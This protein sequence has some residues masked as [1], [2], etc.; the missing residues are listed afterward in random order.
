M[1]Q[2]QP[3]VSHI[4]LL[5]DGTEVS[6][7]VLGRV[8]EITVDQHV[9]LPHMFSLRF[10][11][12]GMKL[13]DEGPFDLATPVTIRAKDVA[14]KQFT[15]IEGEVTALE[16]EFG[17]GMIAELVVHGYDVSHRLY[18]M[19]RSTTYL[20][21]KDSDIAR[22]IAN[23]AGLKADVE[24]TATVYEHIYQHNQSDLRFLQQRARRIGYVCFVADKTL[25]FKK[26]TQTPASVE[27]AWGDD[28]LA[29]SPRMT[30]TEQAPETLIQGWD[31]RKKERILGRA[32]KGELYPKTGETKTGDQWAS[33]FGKNRIT[34]VH[35][36]VV[37]QAEAD[38]VATARQNELS[39]A[40]VEA[41]GE[42]IRRPDVQAGK[43]VTINGLG[44]RF[45]GD[46]LVTRVTHRYTDAGFRSRFHVTGARN[47]LLAEQLNDANS[48]PLWGGVVPAIVTN[49]DDSNGWGRV[50]VKFPWMSDDEESTWA[51]VLAIGGGPTSGLAVIPAVDDEVLVAFQLG[52]FNAP[53]VLG[54]LW[55]G[56]DRL[57]KPVADT[58]AGEQPLVR[59]WHS[60]TGHHISVYDNADNRVEI[61][62][63]GG[64]HIVLSDT[65]NKVEISSNGD[66]KVQA[67]G[68]L[69]LQA[70][71]QVNVK[72]AMINLN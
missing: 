41:D 67:S 70:S 11:D 26:Q 20:N 7:D 63:N 66:L 23:E 9:H 44:K 36:N 22:Q 58:N 65:D 19:P 8:L 31:V 6:P 61:V 10:Y 60:R 56:V 32:Q 2:R 21:V 35:E 5:A 13:L 29:F 49:T 39:G 42:A 52:D 54:G 57:P 40:F 17:E 55:N 45:S 16:P 3:V 47:G 48:A 14:G 28:L 68:N 37:S 51:R 1:A 62:T 30:V 12:P 59:S 24:A 50:K 69:D 27:I 53:M 46:Y 33:N 64:H 43:A 38:I 4:S 71:G 18:R 25:H 34:V 15:L 72:G